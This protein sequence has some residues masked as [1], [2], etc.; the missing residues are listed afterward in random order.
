MQS[1]LTVARP[2]ARGA[3]NVAKTTQAIPAWASALQTLAQL[4]RLDDVHA[5][6][7]NPM[8]K[9]SEVV[10]L[11]MQAAKL[12]NKDI[13]NFLNLLARYQRLTFLPEIDAVFI[14]LMHEDEKVL[15]V[16][17]ITPIAASDETLA[18]LKDRLS[19]RYAR[20]IHLTMRIDKTLIGGGIIR[21]GDQVIDGSLKSKIRD[22]TKHLLT[23]E[24]THAA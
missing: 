3:Y 14:A 24:G 8:L 11:L 12:E 6:I 5:V 9:K 21:V 13:E 10:A 20:E 22:L 16:E 4:V 2:Y 17:F 1:N 23:T 7:K 19:K 18:L 15:D